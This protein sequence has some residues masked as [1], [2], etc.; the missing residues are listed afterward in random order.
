[1]EKRSD[2]N[3]KDVLKESIENK[4]INLF[5]VDSEEEEALEDAPEEGSEESGTPDREEAENKK[6]SIFSRLS[7]GIKKAFS[8]AD[9]VNDAG[10]AARA[11]NRFGQYGWKD[12]KLPS[13]NPPSEGVYITMDGAPVTVDFRD[14]EDKEGVQDF[15]KIGTAGAYDNASR[16]RGIYDAITGYAIVKAYRQQISGG[17]GNGGGGNGGGGG[18]NGGGGGGEGPGEPPVTPGDSGPIPIFK[19]IKGKGAKEGGSSL[20]SVLQNW[21]NKNGGDFDRKALQAAVRQIVQ[22][23]SK[24]MKA[25]Q[26]EVQEAVRVFEDR[27]NLLAERSNPE[28]EFTADN[29]QAAEEDDGI[30]DENI[31]ALDS[32]LSANRGAYKAL[33]EYISERGVF[34]EEEAIDLAF[35]AYEELKE[36]KLAKGREQILNLL[37]KGKISEA[38]RVALLFLKKAADQLKKIKKS[39]QKE[40]GLGQ[41]QTSESL[42]NHAGSYVKLYD[43]GTQVVDKYLEEPEEPEEEPEEKPEEDDKYLENEIFKKFKETLKRLDLHT[44]EGRAGA[45][46]DDQAYLGAFRFYKAMLAAKKSLEKGTIDPDTIKLLDKVEPLNEKFGENE[47]AA[48]KEF[49][50]WLGNMI[51][52]FKESGLTDSERAVK[53]MRAA[54]G[55]KEPKEKGRVVSPKASPGSINTRQIIA[56]RLKASGIKLDKNTPEGQKGLKFVKNLQKVVRRFIARHLQRLGKEE[57][58]QITEKLEAKIIAEIMSSEMDFSNKDIITESID[59]IIIRDLKKELKLTN[60][61]KK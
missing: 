43:V 32:Y 6:E 5:E 12:G 26:I 27:L 56:P 23:I 61:N 25:N 19:N 18:G 8:M 9:K 20:Q 54:R 13:I 39:H 59:K 40:S 17:G 15:L 41:Q 46:K 24:Q 31:Q 42:A 22:D 45:Q 11:D 7:T 57:I 29:I 34:D 16:Q 60:E 28:K 48:G 30:S 33:K 3:F 14:S 35:S 49:K 4:G 36:G 50:I 53:A 47:H 10:G 44:S 52:I 58:K 51:N 1:M 55:V 21:I 2:F 37:D 38:A